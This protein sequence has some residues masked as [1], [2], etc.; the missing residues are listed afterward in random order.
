MLKMYNT[1]TFN[2]IYDNSADFITDYTT[3]ETSISDV[4]KIDNKYVTITWTLL[5]AKYG[6]TPIA[7]WSEEQFKM[8]VFTIMFQYAPTWVKRLDIQDK[9]RALT[10]TDII[11][12]DKTIYNQALAPNQSP[13]T[14]SL[15]EVN[16][17][18]S[19]NT[20][21]KKKSKMN[22]YNDLLM[23]LDTDVSQEYIDKFKK[24]FLYVVKPSYDDIYVTEGEDE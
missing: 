16:F 17:I 1:K 8:K 22:A 10:E 13:S 2:E 18:S 15:D 11:T 12:G 5:T 23:L 24:L 3:Y 9:V 20:A 7:N 19:Q 21:N 14:A 4:N 6:N